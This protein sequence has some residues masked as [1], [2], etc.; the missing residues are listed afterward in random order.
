MASKRSGYSVMYMVTP[1]VYE[2]LKQCVDEYELERLEQLN[3]DQSSTITR[4]RSE[5]ILRDISSQDIIPID[6]S[7]RSRSDIIESNLSQPTLP[8]QV[9]DVVYVTDPSM[10][11]SDPSSNIGTIQTNFSQSGV[12]VTLEDA[13]YMSDPSLHSSDRSR[14]VLN[15]DFTTQTIH[16]ADMTTQTVEPTDISMS[17]TLP[18]SEISKSIPYRSLKLKRALSVPSTEPYRPYNK[19]RKIKSVSM[20][21]PLQMPDRFIQSGT[22]SRTSINLTTPNQSRS[23][24]KL[25]SANVSSASSRDTS[26]ISFDPRITST[27][28]RSS[29][30][31]TTPNQSGSFGRL[32]SANVSTTSSR[33]TS[34]I[35]F[36]P[37]I[38]STPIRQ[39]PAIPENS[40]SRNVIPVLPL[41]A[42]KQTRSPINT[43]TRTGAVQ[44]VQPTRS[45]FQCTICEKSFA[46]KYNLDKH[47]ATLHK[48]SA[49]NDPKY[50]FDRWK[51]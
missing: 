18:Q 11:I 35:S 1:S 6:Q 26:R 21:E 38:T 41:P 10:N 8:Q 51:L 13:V 29:I 34:R 47:M 9:Q 37:R 42:C 49:N 27:P 5:N 44:R 31:L 17:Q 33:D 48:S 20:S 2:L 36:D 23:F 32:P 40:P 4:S 24:G 12:P 7:Y 14:S 16:T 30:N 22:P 28:I 15:P 25:P 45:S 3:K 19:N 46:R 43:R 39:L 50:G